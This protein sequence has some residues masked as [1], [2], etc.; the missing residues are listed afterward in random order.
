VFSSTVPSAQWSA[1]TFV[2]TRATEHVADLKRRPG[3]DIGIHGSI[4]L[5]AGLVDEMRLMLV[6]TVAGK[7]RR[8]FGSDG[9]LQ[10]FDLLDVER[11][12]TGATLLAFQKLS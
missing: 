7:G 3:G 4:S 10:R 1:S 9:A 12:A 2:D 8:L 5:A 6:P 11:T